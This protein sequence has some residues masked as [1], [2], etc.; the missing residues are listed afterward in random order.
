MDQTE[1]KEASQTKRVPFSRLILASA[2]ILGLAVFSNDALTFSIEYRWLFFAA[3][4][5]L[6][7]EC[8]R[9]NHE[10]EFAL[11]L[12][13]MYLFNPISPLFW[14]QNSW[15]SIS[16]FSCLILIWSTQILKEPSEVSTAP[17]AFPKWVFSPTI[18]C[19]LALVGGWITPRSL[20]PI[21]LKAGQEFFDK[22]E[23]DKSLAAYANL[24]TQVGGMNEWVW[25]ARELLDCIQ[26]TAEQ[27]FRKKNLSATSKFLQIERSIAENSKVTLPASFYL[28]AS[29]VAAISLNEVLSDKYLAE[30]SKSET[31]EHKLAQNTLRVL[32]A[33]KR[34]LKAIKYLDPLVNNMRDAYQ[35]TGKKIEAEKLVQ[36]ARKLAAL[37]GRV[38]NL[39]SQEELLSES[40]EIAKREELY[41]ELVLSAKDLASFY[42]NKTEEI[43][44]ALALQKQIPE[45]QKLADEENEQIRQQEQEDEDRDKENAYFEF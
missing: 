24:G 11:N 7:V 39:Q 17:V 20:Y 36:F 13:V 6:C 4:T 33:Q 35:R 31:S 25:P 22:G 34:P 41:S 26:S 21:E 44:K 2:A 3:S 28:L 5:L 27:A 45:W 16:G 32:K 18:I 19:V 14:Q 10:V 38:G 1:S 9:R 30:Y 8:Y 15:K 40:V 12:Y 43:K 29:E 23:I 42:E 37:N